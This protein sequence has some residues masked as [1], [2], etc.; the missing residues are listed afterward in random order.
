MDDMINGWFIGDFSPSVWRTPKFEVA[1]M[2]HEKGEQP[3]PH[4]HKVATEVTAVVKGKV[5]INDE[6]FSVGDIFMVFPNEKVAPYILED[7]EVIV[8]KIPSVPGD[9]YFDDTHSSQG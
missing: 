9:K 7:T 6:V 8:V 2:K 5:Q 3:E 4:Y 1:H